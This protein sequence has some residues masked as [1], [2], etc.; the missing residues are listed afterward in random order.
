MALTLN[1]TTKWPNAKE[2]LRLG[3]TRMGGTPSRVKQ[4]LERV[5]A[6]ISS[7]SAEV[8]LYIKEHGDFIEIGEKMLREWQE[9]STLSLRTD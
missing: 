3:E 2:L 4:I 6:A 9:G 5:R 8:H 1:G 7:T